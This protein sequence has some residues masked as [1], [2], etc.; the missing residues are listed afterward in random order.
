MN[1]A[2][3]PAPIAT[4]LNLTPVDPADIEATTGER[5][6]EAHYENGKLWIGFPVA[7]NPQPSASGKSLLIA[8]TGSKKSLP[9]QVDGKQVVIA[10]NVYYSAK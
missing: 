10:A 5:P 2:T 4:G 9:F 8:S 7:R 3:A 6:L 1:A